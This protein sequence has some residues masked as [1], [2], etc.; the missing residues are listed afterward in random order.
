MANHFIKEP[1]SIAIT[2]ASSG[3]GATLAKVYAQKGITLFLSGRNEERLYSVARA[4]TEKGAEVFTYPLDVTSL[5]AVSTWLAQAWQERPIDLIIAN[6]GISA[7]SG[8]KG[9]KWDQ[10]KQIFDTNIYGVLH[11][12]E[13]I[14]PHMQKR[15][16]G[17]I[18]IVSSL[19]AF[20]GLPSSPSYSASKAA[21]KTYG[22]ALRGLLQGTGIHVT[23]IT[24][25]YIDTPMTQVNHF[26]MPFLWP[27]DKAALYIKK[28]LVYN[29]ARIAFPFP[30][31][32][33]IWLLSIFSP[34]LTDWLFKRLPAKPSI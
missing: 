9:E 12:V 8:G 5:P 13:A 22:E 24:P 3:L 6:A 4:C 21:V 11:T 33:L 17:H 14:L 20:R 16:A 29:P 30:L 18:A 25:G 32:T 19:A 31:A 28:R 34:G 1:Q 15:Q 27:V 7:G 23:V 10:V 26:P 2:G